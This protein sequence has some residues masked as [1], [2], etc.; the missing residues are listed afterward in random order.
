MLFAAGRDAAQTPT[1]TQETAGLGRGVYAR[2]H[3][4]MMLADVE[5]VSVCLVYTGLYVS[6][7]VQCVYG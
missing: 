3:A 2:E 4:N 7:V 1:I 5:A 6:V